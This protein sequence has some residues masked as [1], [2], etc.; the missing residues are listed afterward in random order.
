MT[1]AGLNVC[2]Q[3]RLPTGVD[4]YIGRGMVGST[5]GTSE[6]RTP[7][8]RGSTTPEKTFPRGTTKPGTTSSATRDL[9]TLPLT[10]RTRT[11]TT[12]AMTPGG[13]TAPRLATTLSATYSCTTPATIALHLAITAPRTTTLQGPAMPQATTTGGPAAPAERCQ[14]APTQLAGPPTP[15]KLG[16][17]GTTIAD[18][19]V[20]AQIR[21]PTGEPPGGNDAWG[22]D[23]LGD[24]ATGRG[25][26]TGSNTAEDDDDD[27]V[28]ITRIGYIDDTTI[29]AVSVDADTNCRALELSQARELGEASWSTFQ[30]APHIQ[31]APRL[32]GPPVQHGALGSGLPRGLW[33]GALATRQAPNLPGLHRPR[34]AQLAWLT[35]IQRRAGH[36]I[37]GSFRTTAGAAL[38]TE[39]YL[40]PIKFRLPLARTR[41]LTRL[42]TR[43]AY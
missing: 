16:P 31:P 1:I 5:A 15:Y 8:L 36:A 38:D 28:Q 33:M 2:A 37:T 29:I 3:I 4:G 23:P 24:A 9:A 32:R 35:A 25:G 17:L 12:T 13:P 39:L 7:M 22:S 41:A 20:C 34:G 27:D 43:P 19:D 18:L 40:T 30:P 10:P 21:I 14:L 6:P 11:T 42:A 26:L